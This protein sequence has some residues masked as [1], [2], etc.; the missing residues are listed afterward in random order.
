MAVT[1]QVSAQC[2]VVNFIVTPEGLEAARR[3]SVSQTISQLPGASAGHGGE[4]R[5]APARGGEAGAQSGRSFQSAAYCL[6]FK[7]CR[8]WFDGRTSTRRCRVGWAAVQKWPPISRL[9]KGGAEQAGGAKR[10]D[11]GLC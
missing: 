2:T 4:L 3:A 9:L 10:Q 1:C 11:S 7:R 6:V 5:E 8:R